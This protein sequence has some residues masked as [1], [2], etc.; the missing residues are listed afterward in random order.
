MTRTER[1]RLTD[2]IRTAIAASPLSRYEISRRSG[3]PEAS[4]SNFMSGKLGLSVGS[5]ERLAP[6]LG[7]EIVLKKKR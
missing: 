2:K 3:V 6:V 5:I 4:L 7:L 1:A